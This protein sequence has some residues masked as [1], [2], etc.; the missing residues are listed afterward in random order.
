MLREMDASEAPVVSII[1]PVYNQTHLLKKLIRSIVETAGNVPYEIVVTDDG[2]RELVRPAIEPMPQLKILRHETSRGAAAAR[3]TAVAASRG[4]ILFF[5][6]ADTILIPGSMI[7]VG[8]RF[9]NEPDLGALNGGGAADPANPEDGFTPRYRAMIDHIQQDIRAPEICSLFTPRCGV[10]RRKHFDAAGGFDPKFPGASVEEYEFGYRL[11]RVTPIRFDA[12]IGVRHHYAQFW[13]N[14]RNY[15]TRVRLW[16]ALFFH[17]RRF[18]NFGSCTGSAGFGSIFAFLWIPFLVLPP[19][20][21]CVGVLVSLSV[22][23]WGYRDVFYWS[24]RLK[25][26]MFF[27]KSILIT[28]WLCIMI[29]LAAILGALDYLTGRSIVQRRN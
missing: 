21:S 20:L 12:K 8:E 29:V 16:M 24:F 19:P 9:K 18:D 4:E 15:F 11:S 2:S 7:R 22:F 23:A 10:I 27:I 26:P 3:N 25:G 28:W 13:K 17:R 5:L 14:S 1:V 6:D